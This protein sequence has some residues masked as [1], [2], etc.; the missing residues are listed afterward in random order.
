MTERP[1][2]IKIK[3]AAS[4]FV[5]RFIGAPCAGRFIQRAVWPSPKTDILVSPSIT[6]Q[7]WFRAADW[8][9]CSIVFEGSY[10]ILNCIVGWTTETSQRSCYRCEKYCTLAVYSIRPPVSHNN[11]LSCRQTFH[12]LEPH[13]FVC[14]FLHTKLQRNP[15]DN[16][17]KKFPI[18]NHYLAIWH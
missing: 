15:D 9:R 5:G 6:I 7:W 11:D 12:N 4:N 16:T 1:T 14:S 17:V 2:P 8:T 3:L 13:I 18:F 10:F